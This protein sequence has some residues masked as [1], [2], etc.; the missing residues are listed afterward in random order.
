MSLWDGGNVTKFYWGEQ[1]SHACTLP[2]RTGKVVEMDLE[3]EER[4]E[5][6]DLI[7]YVS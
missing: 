2:K 3:V 4:G 1:C 5:I 6:F 7:H